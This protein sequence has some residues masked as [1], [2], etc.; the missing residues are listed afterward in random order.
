MNLNT[1]RRIAL[2]GASI[3]TLLLSKAYNDIL[4]AGTVYT[5]TRTPGKTELTLTSA[6]L[7]L[8]EFRLDRERH[9]L[10]M[11]LDLV[12]HGVPVLA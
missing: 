10:K 4:I 12:A 9:Y 11:A 3:P 2:D 5:N 6:D 8:A 1:L 7:E